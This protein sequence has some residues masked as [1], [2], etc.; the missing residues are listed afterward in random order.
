MGATT[1]P[2]S[3]TESSADFFEITTVDGVKFRKGELAPHGTLT[4]LIGADIPV[5]VEG[6][7]ES[8]DWIEVLLADGYSVHLPEARIARLVTCA[9]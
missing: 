4:D 8:G 7:E 9:A 5:L 3:A 2:R 1:D 6:Y